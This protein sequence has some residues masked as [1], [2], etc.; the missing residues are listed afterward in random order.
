MTI[1]PTSD[2]AIEM[3]SRRHIAS[4]VDMPQNPATPRSHDPSRQIEILILNTPT[5]ALFAKS[6]SSRWTENRSWAARESYTGLKSAAGILIVPH[7]LGV[8]PVRNALK[9]S[10]APLRRNWHIAGRA[11]AMLLVLGQWSKP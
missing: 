7:N 6:S 2:P 11:L 3:L 9:N 10:V 5:T 4:F 8:L 1:E